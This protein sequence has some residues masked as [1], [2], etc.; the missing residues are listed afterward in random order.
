MT[1]T[2]TG[3][4]ADNKITAPANGEA[5]FS[6]KLEL[7]AAGKKAYNDNFPN[8]SYVEASPS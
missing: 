6:V 5:T 1:I 3:L 2:Y 4:T 8:G 7:T